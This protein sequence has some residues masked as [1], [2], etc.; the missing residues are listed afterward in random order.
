MAAL[1]VAPTNAAPELPIVAAL[2]VT[3]VTVPA[4]VR[5]PPVI[6]PV[7]V[8]DPLLIILPTVILPVK[9]VFVPITLPTR[10]V[11]PCA[12]KLPVCRLA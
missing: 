5:L 8:D 4:V 10:L 7:V 2:T 3:A 6:L 11:V 1:T 12:I 9:F